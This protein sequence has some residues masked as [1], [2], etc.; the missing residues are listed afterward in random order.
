[1]TNRIV[2]LKSKQPA[3]ALALAEEAIS[4]QGIEDALD[5]ATFRYKH[6]LEAL[7]TD[8]ATRETSLRDEYFAEVAQI[9][10]EA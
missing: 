10:A 9:I 1:M 5:A 4:R 3:G 6:R 2:P 7:R 8:A